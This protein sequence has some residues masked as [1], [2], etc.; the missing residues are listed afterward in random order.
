MQLGV[1]H[2]DA[3]QFYGPDVANELINTALYPCPQQLALVS[4]VGNRRTDTGGWLPAQEPDEFRHDI[5]AGDPNQP[6]RLN[7]RQFERQLTSTIQARDEGLIAGI[8]LSNISLGHFFLRPNT[9]KSCTY[10]TPS[11]LVD[12]SSQS[13]LD[14]C[15]TR[16]IAFVPFFPLGSGFAANN[17]VLGKDT[18]RRTAARLRPNRN[19]KECNS[20]H[21]LWPRSYLGQQRDLVFGELPVDVTHA[22]S[23]SPWPVRRGRRDG[24]FG[25][26]RPR[27]RR[28]VH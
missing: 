12:R 5:E 18:V 13:L 16:N 22:S 20:F 8:G 3:A 15:T 28:F 26:R 4:K 24:R 27:C 7:R 17:P 6:S 9:P 23:I 10:K 1:D 25:H 11:N 21:R 2:I 19:N 14:E